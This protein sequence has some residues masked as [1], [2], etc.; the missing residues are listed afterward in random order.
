M[1]TICGNCKNNLENTEKQ[2]KFKSSMI[3]HPEIT[4]LTTWLYIL[5]VLSLPR[6]RFYKND[7]MIFAS[8]LLLNI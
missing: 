8:Y 6:S 4:I 1:D 7:I 3:P 2:K 5:L